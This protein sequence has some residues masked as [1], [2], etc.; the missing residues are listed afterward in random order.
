MPTHFEMKERQGRE[1][2]CNR[3]DVLG[4]D[5][6]KAICRRGSGGKDRVLR[7][8][9]VAWGGGWSETVTKRIVT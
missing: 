5:I 2:L 3:L 8:P 9:K 6:A 7:H 1:I 4:N